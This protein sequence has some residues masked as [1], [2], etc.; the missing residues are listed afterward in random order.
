MDTM[1][2]KALLIGRWLLPYLK[3]AAPVTLVLGIIALVVA[4]W[5]L[6]PRWELNGEFPLAA[7][8][9][10]AVVTL[11]VVLV[12]AMVWGMM[13]ARRLR[14]VN[15]RQAEAQKEQEDPILPMERK[16]QRLLDR[17]L[18]ALKSNLPGRKGIYRLPWYLAMGLEDAGKTSLIQRSGQTYTLTNVT[19]N[20]PVAH[21]PAGTDGADRL[22][23]A[24]LCHLHQDGPALRIWP[25]GADPE[26][27]GQGAGPGLYLQPR[28][29]DG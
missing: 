8:Q 6:G 15:V 16:Q 10:R 11:G 1:W 14:K 22:P 19:R 18:A 2:R 12:V 23:P 17:Q 27:A 24:R 3:N 26:Q 20:N 4:T 21:A 5:W 13:L 29:P 25:A 28:R 7:W 9:M